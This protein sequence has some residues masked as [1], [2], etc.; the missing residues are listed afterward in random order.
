MSQSE[1][2]RAPGWVGLVALWSAALVF[3][4][5]MLVAAPAGAAIAESDLVW[6][7]DGEAVAEDLY[8]VGN[9]V[10]I[11]GRVEGDLVAVAAERV[12]IGGTV[13]GSVTALAPLVVV[14]GEV[15]GSVRGAAGEVIVTGRVGGDVLV[16]AWDMQLRGV[17]ERDLL[18]A[19]WSAVAGGG[20]G[21]DVRGFFR[22]LRLAGKV[23]RNVEVRVDRL[24]VGRDMAVQGD[25]DYRTDHVSGSQYL[26]DGVV[27]SVI[28]RGDLPP[29]IRI[30][31]FRLMAVVLMSLMVMVG[32]MLVVAGR[33]AAV[34]AARERMVAMPWK[35]LGKGVAVLSAP[36]VG[37]VLLVGIVTAGLPVYVW[38]PLLLAGI[39]FLVIASGAWLLVV[40]ISH[41]P[42][43]VATGRKLGRVT[44]RGWSMASE[45][46]VGA[47]VL[48]ALAQIPRLG[49]AAAAA[50]TVLGAGAWFG[51]RQERVARR[52]PSTKTKRDTP[53]GF[54]DEALSNRP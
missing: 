21:R 24:R 4:G 26:E 23:D 50:V 29:N 7:T 14:Q 40:L 6:I 1:K 5:V 8:A 43:A 11:G 25:L 46:L 31:A 41:I 45:Y 54:D 2:C 42:V 13:T 49:T 3:G 16:A 36:L 10:R 47:V 18:V 9:E 44:G 17:V 48:L 37:G 19:G 38:G 33:S 28:S 32:G 51:K 30:R 22:S 27:G 35:S 34:E 15:Q 52:P 53:P 39:P 20:V 12:W